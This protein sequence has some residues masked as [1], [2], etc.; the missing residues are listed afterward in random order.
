[1]PANRCPNP[2]C[3]YFNR[4]LPNNAKVCP[5]C[6]TPLGNIIPPAPNNPPTQQPPQQPP[7]PEQ[8]INQPAPDYSTQYQQ[9]S[10][11][12]PT[13]QPYTPPLPRLPVLKLIHSTGREFSL[14]GEVGSIGR[15]TQS[16][17]T[18]PEIDLSGIPQEGIV[19]R[20]HARV[21]WDWSQNTYMIVDTSVNGIYLNGNLLNSG[22]SYRLSNGD[23]LQLGQDNLIVFKVV[24]M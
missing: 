5:W 7:P 18:P 24:V 11:V 20:R 10:Y 22:V 2:T 21:F 19:S 1:M 6:S 4:A 23:L 16:M 3:E 13:P 8:P 15:R 14:S 9:R 12:P 17:P